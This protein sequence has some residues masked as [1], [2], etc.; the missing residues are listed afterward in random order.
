MGYNPHKR[1]A[2]LYHPLLAFCAETKEILQ[3][4][5]RSGG[6]YTSNGVVDFVRQ[7][8][9]HL[10]N[11]TRILFR[12]DSGFFV[13]KLLEF[14]DDRD[15]DYLIKGKFKGMKSLL[16]TKQ[17]MRII[18]NHDW[19]STEFTLQYGTWSR[20]RK[21][22]AV[23]QEKEIDAK[24]ADTLFEMKEY[25]YFCYVLTDELAPW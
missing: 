4:W 5:L 15:H 20:S 14:L 9:A 11:R 13:G 10:P 25:D 8:L 18:G 3:G 2:A 16:K 19:G 7:L 17:W 6:V 1:G 23:R 22:V 12:G 21:F 24:D